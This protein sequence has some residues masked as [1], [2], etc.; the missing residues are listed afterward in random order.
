MSEI[1]RRTLLVSVGTAVGAAVVAGCATPAPDAVLDQRRRFSD[2]TPLP[3]PTDTGQMSVEAAL[4]ARRSRREFSNR[5]LSIDVIGQLFWAGQGVTSANGYRSAPSAG[6]RFPIEL[7]ALSSST[8]MHYLPVG[9]MVEQRRDETSKAAL[10]SAAFD[11][12]HVS[13]SPITFVIAGVVRRTEVEYGRVAPGLM[14]REAGHVAQNM[15]LQATA[16]DLA[17]VPVGGF[18]PAAVTR[19]LAL[20]PGEEALYLMPVGH[21]IGS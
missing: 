7:Y 11:Q 1:G 12:Q 5:P 18:D 2:P 21:A 14:T 3:A 20:P 16:L 13:A 10:P 15:L 9:H 6:A 17:A 4:G 8:L 19:L